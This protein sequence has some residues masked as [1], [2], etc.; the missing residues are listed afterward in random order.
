MAAVV[1]EPV[2]AACSSS[3]KYPAGEVDIDATGQL[4]CEKSRVGPAAALKGPFRRPSAALDRCMFVAPACP[5]HAPGGS[6]V[7]LASEHMRAPAGQQTPVV[8]ESTMVRFNS[9]EAVRAVAL[10]WHQPAPGRI[11]STATMPVG[12]EAESAD[13]TRTVRHPCVPAR[14]DSMTVFD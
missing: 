6:P 4:H 14:S 5:S 1:A 8:L 10:R 7:S 11:S 3:R 13:V 2:E 9:T 12:N